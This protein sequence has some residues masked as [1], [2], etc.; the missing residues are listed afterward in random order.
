MKKNIQLINHSVTL[1]S[2]TS[3][4]DT[5]LIYSNTIHNFQFDVVNGVIVARVVEEFKKRLYNIENQTSQ[6]NALNNSLQFMNTVLST[7]QIPKNLHIAIEFQIP[8]TSKRVDF[9][10]SGVD[11]DD[12]KNIVI[13]EL[14][15][16]SDATPL[17]NPTTIKTFVGQGYRRTVHPSYQA[18]T[19]AKTIDE[20]NES[21]RNNDIN[22]L[23]VRF[24]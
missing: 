16:W 17:N 5:M 14:K 20:F 11:N 8:L 6:I 22:L 3:F 13:I 23:L 10:I 12:Q 2:T 4:N 18:Y 24:S 7:E 15:Q 19:Y 21:I 1:K 9:M